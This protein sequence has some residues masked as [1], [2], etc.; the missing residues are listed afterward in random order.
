MKELSS[1][2][3]KWDRPLNRYVEEK[4]K[5]AKDLA[6]WRAFINSQVKAKKTRLLGHSTLWRLQKG[7]C[8]LCGKPMDPLTATRDHLHPVS[9]GGKSKHHNILWAHKKCNGKRGNKGIY[10]REEA[11]ELLKQRALSERTQSDTRS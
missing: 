3:P 9:T 4:T 11:L 5:A 8:W 1:F 2:A 6:E 7:L 10:T